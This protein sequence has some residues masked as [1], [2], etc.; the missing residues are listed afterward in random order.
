MPDEKQDVKGCQHPEER[1]QYSE[2]SKSCCCLENVIRKA[3]STN[4]ATEKKGA[5][6]KKY[7]PFY[8]PFLDEAGFNSMLFTKDTGRRAYKQLREHWVERQPDMVLI[9]GALIRVDRP[10]FKRKQLTE[11]EPKDGK[12]EEELEDIFATARAPYHPLRERMSRDFELLD[13][14]LGQLSKDL[15]NTRIV[16]YMP[17]DDFAYTISRFVSYDCKVKTREINKKLKSAKKVV[18]EA[19]KRLKGSKKQKLSDAETV[20]LKKDIKELDKKIEDYEKEYADLTDVQQAMRE[21]KESQAHQVI[22]RKVYDEFVA[23]Y[24]EICAKYKNVELVAEA[25][26]VFEVKDFKF[27]YQH[28]SHNQDTPLKQRFKMLEKQI[29]N[30]AKNLLEQ[31]IQAV[32]EGHHG[33]YRHEL[34]KAGLSTAEVMGENEGKFFADMVVDNIHLITLSPFE[35]QDILSMIKAG[36]FPHRFAGGKPKG[37]RSHYM[38][39]R[40]ENGSVAGV[41]SLVRDDIG[42]VGGEFISY[43]S[44]K[45]RRIN[46]TNA[47]LKSEK[48]L[49]MIHTY[50]DDHPGRPDTDY[51][52]IMGMNEALKRY[53][54]NNPTFNGINLVPSTLI[55]GGDHIE[56]NS[57]GWS[58]A[59]AEFHR[60][61][62]LD[63]IDSFFN[64][65]RGKKKIIVDEIMGQVMVKYDI[66]DLIKDFMWHMEHA[67]KGPHE[68]ME[69][70]MNFSSRIMID[71]LKMMDEKSRMKYL[72]IG[73]PGNHAF[74]T[75]RPIG[76]DDFFLL[77]NMMKDRMTE[78]KE[79]CLG[80]RG[81]SRVAYL[82][83]YGKNTTGEQLLQDTLSILVCHDP[84]YKADPITTILDYCESGKFPV[85]DVGFGGH[86]HAAGVGAKRK[87]GADNTAFFGVSMPALK[88][89]DS[90]ELIKPGIARIQGTV[91]IGIPASGHA[92]YFFNDA[93]L[94]RRHA[95]QRLRDYATEAINANILNKKED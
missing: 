6:T 59:G 79:V 67:L 56:G 69:D 43:E 17:D 1:G 24:K 35:D 84:I 21:P 12:E 81:R 22:S 78:G 42:R 31:G 49:P 60:D 14:R 30:S 19:Q 45:S 65:F 94:L 63:V 66:D 41:F 55:F 28:N 70:I 52:L 25:K 74:Y 8:I 40:Y 83:D 47:W 33:H 7:M 95:E 73:V 2:D 64:N 86:Y 58:G 90:T 62:P 36:G 75:T 18:K 26:A 16:L 32:V 13:Y 20:Q 68:N 89:S 92:I 4:T 48:K 46:K 85:V 5:E 51:S 53:L 88:R 44:L 50:S 76:L 71:M 3:I 38:M 77:K 80:G 34:I 82:D 54:N 27:I 39:N 37:T 61:D 72:A 11:W 87:S 9:S 29:A 15:P 23:K 91:D 57:S 93:K 10:E